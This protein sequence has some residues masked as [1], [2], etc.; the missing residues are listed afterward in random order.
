MAEPLRVLLITAASLVGDYLAKAFDCPRYALF[1][2]LQRRPDIPDTLGID[3]TDHDSLKRAFARVD[4]DVVL[5]CAALTNVDLCQTRQQEAFAVNV[6]GPQAIARLC[7]KKTKLVFF[8]SDYIFDGRNGPYT[9]EDI[10]NPVDYYGRTKLEAE[11]FI[12]ENV[13]RHL[14]IR[15]TVVYGNEAA[16]KNFA[17]SLVKMLA[18]GQPRKVPRDQIGN[19]T[20]GFNLARIVEE[21][22]RTDKNGIFNV[23]GNDLID[24]YAFALEI[25]SCF[26]LDKDLVIPVSTAELLQP[27]P[28]PLKAGLTIDKVRSAVSERII[29]VKEGLELFK[30]E[31]SWKS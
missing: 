15:T 26:G 31:L 18:A 11:Q 23:V 27:A 4:P 21:L 5:L 30:K 12:R 17:Y 20:Y 3:L 13:A 25:C 2:S 24:R 14:I 10:P 16:A 1:K 6:A 7:G 19:P 8:S 29:G 28:R 22:V 9:E